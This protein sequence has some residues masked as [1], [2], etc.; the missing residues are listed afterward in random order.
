MITR[1]NFIKSAGA[2]AA[3]T[4]IAPAVPSLLKVNE[5]ERMIASGF[6][7]NQI[8]YIDKPIQLNISNV[9]ISGCRFIATK[10]LPFWIVVAPNVEYSMR[11]DNIFDSNGRRIG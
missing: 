5:L 3:L 10:D 1:R 8:F 6:V 9:T 2:L 4:V 7:H 11:I